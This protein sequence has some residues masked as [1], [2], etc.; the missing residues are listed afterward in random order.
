MQVGGSWPSWSR[1]S[2]HLFIFGYSKSSSFGNAYAI[3]IQTGRSNM[4]QSTSQSSS[5]TIVLFHFLNGCDC[6]W[7]CFASRTSR[8]NR[9]I[10]YATSMIMI[11]PS[12]TACNARKTGNSIN[13]PIA[14]SMR[15]TSYKFS[16]DDKKERC[17]RSLPRWEDASQS[18]SSTSCLKYARSERS[19]VNTNAVAPLLSWQL[20]RAILKPVAISVNVMVYRIL[21]A[22]WD[23]ASGLS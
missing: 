13:A 23:S 1:S 3:Q 11:G 8:A 20:E 22:S 7:C 6:R 4:K 14:L 10:L 2:F 19:S 15:I 17:S 21:F 12:H 18:Y 9:E 16:L 5:S